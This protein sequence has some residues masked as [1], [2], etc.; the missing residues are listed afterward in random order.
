MGV[1]EEP[2]S[3]RECQNDPNLLGREY[4]PKKVKTRTSI[5]MHTHAHIVTASPS[6]IVIERF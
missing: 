6:T 1:A 3:R 2:K 4:H 5:H